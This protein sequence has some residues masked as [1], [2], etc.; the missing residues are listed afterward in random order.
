MSRTRGAI[1]IP[2]FTHG[3]GGG[4]KFVAFLAAIG[5][6]LLIINDPAGAARF[7][8]TVIGGLV[9]FFRSLRD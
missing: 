1:Q 7:V 9:E 6:L 8:T 4:R 2:R 5:A 3:G